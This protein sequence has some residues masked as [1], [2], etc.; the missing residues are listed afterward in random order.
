MKP[1]ETQRVRRHVVESVFG[2]EEATLGRAGD[3]EA[4]RDVGE[5]PLG[6]TAADVG[7]AAGKPDLRDAIRIVIR[8]GRPEG[9]PGSSPR[10]DY[11]PHHEPIAQTALLA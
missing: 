8:Q 7:V 11:N 2:K 10:G 5:A 6:M 4:Q 1:P 9:G 3:H